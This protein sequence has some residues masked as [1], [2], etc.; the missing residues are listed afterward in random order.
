MI[1]PPEPLLTGAIGAALLGRDAVL[2]A[3][4]NNLPL[5][6]S[7]HPLQEATFFA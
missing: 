2:S 5:T 6:R 7:R 1:I 3:A 4:K